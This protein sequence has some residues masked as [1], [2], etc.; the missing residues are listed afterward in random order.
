MFH[1]MPPDIPKGRF[2]VKHFVQN[3]TWHKTI[4]SKEKKGTFYNFKNWQILTAYNPFSKN[5]FR[6]LSLG[7]IN[8]LQ[9]ICS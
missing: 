3:E 8:F 9:I 5:Y 7:H 6:H 4:F 1:Y 2:H